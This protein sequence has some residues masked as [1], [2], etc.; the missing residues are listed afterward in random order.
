MNCSTHVAQKSNPEFLRNLFSRYTQVPLFYANRLEQIMF[1]ALL[2]YLYA[3]FPSSQ[4]RFMPSSMR[5]WHKYTA[6][7]QE[8]LAK[9][10]ALFWHVDQASTLFKGFNL[11]EIDWQCASSSS[12]WGPYQNNLASLV[13]R[14]GLDQ[15]LTKWAHV[16]TLASKRNLSLISVLD[17]MNFPNT[18]EAVTSFCLTRSQRIHRYVIADH[19][20]AQCNPCKRVFRVEIAGVLF[21]QKNQLWQSLVYDQQLLRFLEHFDLCA[22]NE[23]R[24]VTK[25]QNLCPQKIKFRFALLSKQLAA[26]YQKMPKTMR[27]AIIRKTRYFVRYS[28]LCTLSKKCN[29]SKCRAKQLSLER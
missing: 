28:Y 12:A 23:V 19:S 7:R 13:K 2:A 26:L 8:I 29:I 21:I 18:S 20:W 16:D 9:T 10:L 27:K 22:N 5:H 3:H 25:W 4:L 17:A 1:Q 11:Y 6:S 24:A 15:R 14:I